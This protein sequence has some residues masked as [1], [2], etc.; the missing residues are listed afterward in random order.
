MAERTARPATRLEPSRPA[1]PLAHGLRAWRRT[2]PVAA[3]R[4]EG[5]DRGDAV[6][7]LRELLTHA[8]AFEVARRRASVPL[9]S[10]EDLDDLA[11][12]AA[13]DAVAAVLA[14]LDTFRG[15]S[16]FTTWVCKFALREA[17]ASVRCRA[18]QE[19]P[20]VLGPLE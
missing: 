1:V 4:S 5:R 16:R 7:R 10:D 12:Q 17:A 2:W 8:A 13:D 14:R 18:W 11:A 9:V 6:A 15:A 3:L 19:R 20:V